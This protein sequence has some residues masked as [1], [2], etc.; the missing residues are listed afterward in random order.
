[1]HTDKPMAT[2]AWPHTSFPAT[3]QVQHPASIWGVLSLHYTHCLPSQTRRTCIASRQ[4]H[5]TTHRYWSDVR[6]WKTPAGSVVIWLLLRNLLRRTHRVSTFARSACWRP[7]SEACSWHT[8]APLGAFVVPWLSFD[9]GINLQPNIRIISNNEYAHTPIHTLMTSMSGIQCTSGRRRRVCVVAEVK[10]RRHVLP[11]SRMHT[12][13][14]NHTKLYMFMYIWACGFVC[15]HGWMR[16]RMYVCW[17]V[18]IHVCTYV[19]LYVSIWWLKKV[20]MCKHTT[21]LVHTHLNIPP[22]V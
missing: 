10:M 7:P 17:Y 18:G 6:P 21:M 20:C 12:C 11:C 13:L 3:C 16:N 4:P 1:M 19:C 15:V 14:L 5:A 2:H 9:T 8:Y 22:C